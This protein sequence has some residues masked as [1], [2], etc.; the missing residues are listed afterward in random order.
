MLPSSIMIQNGELPDAPGVYLMKDAK[1]AVLYV[2]KATSLARRVR[3]HFE[4]PHNRLIEE[5]TAQ[6]RAIDYIQKP[7]ALEALVLEANLIK[8][9]WPKY[10]TDQK[11]DKS[12]LYLGITREA[13]PRPVLVRG[14][15]L[16]DASRKQFKAVYGP[17]TS[18]RSLRAALDVMRK[19][20]PWS[21]C[22][23]GQARPCFYVHLGQCPG[24]CTGAITRIAYGKIIKNLMDFFA[25]K[26]SIIVKRYRQEMEA[27]AKAKKFEEAAI[28]RNRLFALEHI[29]DVAIMKRDEPS[30]VSAKGGSGLDFYGRIEGYD[31]SH[32]GGT[33]HVGSMVVFEQGAPAKAEYRTFTIKTVTGSNDFAALQEVLRRRLHHREWAKPDLILIDGGAPQIRAIEKL[34]DELGIMIPFVGMSKGPRRKRHDLIAPKGE[35]DLLQ[36]CH[37]HE[38]LLIQ[39]RDEAH[40]FAIGF[41]RKKRGKEFLGK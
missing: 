15:E 9:Y 1:G 34:W 3:Q 30:E 41:H 22:A 19:A 39:V 20:I 26:K 24:V 11:D 37:K 8:Q 21:T 27:A 2:G 18:G 7:T 25:G 29:Q 12:F 13:F 28:L 32:I 33:S 16:T 40:R 10:N 31:I 5:M 6:V 35:E 38:E 14:H 17:Y 36:Q 23:P 4:R